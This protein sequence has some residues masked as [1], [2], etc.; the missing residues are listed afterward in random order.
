MKIMSYRQKL[1]EK[2]RR[3]VENKKR[4][5]KLPVTQAEVAANPRYF[6]R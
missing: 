4:L 5:Q 2:R 1:I 6:G 3:R